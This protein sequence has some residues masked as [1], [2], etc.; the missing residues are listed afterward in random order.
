MPVLKAHGGFQV[1]AAVKNY[2]GTPSDRLTSR[3]A[4]NSV[5]TGGMGTQMA[6]TRMPVLNILDM[7][8]IGVERGPSSSYAGARQIN[9]IAASLDPVALDYWASKNILIPEVNRLP[10]GRGPAMNPDGTEPGTFGFWLRLSMN[11]LHNAGIWATM[12]EAEIT[13]IK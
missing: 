2:M 8:Y 5:G 13:I 11:E 7:I 1:T 12:D 3:R 10:G 6:Y 9:K 4:H